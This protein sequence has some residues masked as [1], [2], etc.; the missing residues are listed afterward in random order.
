MES[1]GSSFSGLDSYFRALAQTPARLARRACSVSTSHE[2]MSQVKARSGS[3]MQRTLRWYDLVGFGIGG[4]VGAG[5]F[6]I[7]GHASRLRAGPSVVISYAI[8]GLCALLS[9]FC[10]TEFAVD[11]PVA[12][13]AFSYLRITFGEFAAFLTGANLIMDYVMSNAAVARGFT[14]YLGSAIGISTSKWRL[15]IHGLPDGFNEIDTF[16][17]LVVLAITLI[18]CYSTRES[19]LVNMLLTILH[20]LFIG[21]VIL[22]GF[23]KGDWKNF[24]QPANPNNPSGFFPFGAPG[25]FNGAA[26]VYLSYIGYDAVSTLAEEV[27]DPVKDIPI[28]VSGS[29]IIVTILYCLMAASMSMLLPYDMI[30]ADAPFSAAFRGESDGWQ[31]VSNVIGMGASFGILTSLLVAMLGQARYLCVIG[32][33]NV[34]PAWF[35]RVHPKTSTPVNASAFLGIFTAAIALFTDL[36]VL[37]NLV[38]IG[39]LFVFYMV[40]NALVYRRYVAI[41]TTN[42]WPTLSFLCSFSFTSILFTLIWHFMPNGKGKAFMLGACAVIAIAIIQL[43]HC[44]VPQARKPEFWGVPLMPWIPCASIFLNIFLLGS[45]DGPS[46]VRFV[47]FSA[48]AVLVYVLYS[49]HASFDAEGGGSIGQKNGEIARESDESED[50]INSF[51]V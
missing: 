27:H 34:V 16:A 10:Y 39:T 50:H 1:H 13:G 25:V 3:V 19:S 22:M 29:V 11:M 20:I 2:E 7:T 32:R 43:F 44:I 45:L 51:K 8:A 9:S 33:S 4:M 48:L 15:V 24:T 30:D 21:F 18:I 40:A 23:W 38:S 36:N 31:W 12:G 41:G 26:M 42:P 6:V 35:A 49:V 37:L 47:F 14:A 17:V 5:V 28:G 46:Y